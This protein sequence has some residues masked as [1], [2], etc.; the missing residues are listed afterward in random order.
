MSH[1]N[2]QLHQ[3]RDIAFKQGLLSVT[4]VRTPS[5]KYIV[6]F[7]FKSEM[8]SNDLDNA[9]LI[10]QKNVL[11]VFTTLDAAYSAVRPLLFELDD[12][13]VSVNINDDERVKE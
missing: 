10:T 4:I 6:R 11:R 13:F 9:T 2:L 8:G 1:S 3:V 7:H 5:D 12:I